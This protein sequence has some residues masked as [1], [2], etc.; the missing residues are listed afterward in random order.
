MKVSAVVDT[1]FWSAACHLELEVFLYELFARP[2][3]MP[4]PVINE[5]LSQ[6]PGKPRRVYPYRQRLKIALEDGRIARRDPVQPYPRYGAGERACI[7]LA[8]ERDLV[9]LMND[10]RPYAEA[11][12]LGISV[13]SMP[14]LVITLAA[15]GIM[16]HK[17]ARNHLE[18]LRDRTSDA[19]IDAAL[20]ILNNVSPRE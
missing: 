10:Y 12:R 14:E 15:T 3:F 17:A 13:M 2:L 18:T 6:P 16:A 5:V 19:L 8:K 20:R 11:R 4:A 1:S 9:L 7:G